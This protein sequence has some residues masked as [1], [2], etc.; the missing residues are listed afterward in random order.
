MIADINKKSKEELLEE[1][2][3]RN[4]HNTLEGE[5]YMAAMIVKSSTD[6]QISAKEIKEAVDKFKEVAE[7][8]GKSSDNLSKKVFWLNIVLAG[9]TLIGAI[10]TVILAFK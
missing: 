8:T 7:N 5:Q 3:N 6:I 2:A 9:A 10:A 1:F 4:Y